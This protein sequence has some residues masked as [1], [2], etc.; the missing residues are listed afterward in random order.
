LSSAQLWVR[1]FEQV[2]CYA[3][4]CNCF[5]GHYCVACAQYCILRLL[6]GPHAQIWG[7]RAT[8]DA[9]L[10]T[11]YRAWRAHSAAMAPAS[12]KHARGCRFYGHACVLV[13]MACGCCLTMQAGR[14]KDGQYFIQYCDCG[15]QTSVAAVWWH[16]HICVQQVWFLSMSTGFVGHHITVITCTVRNLCKL[17][18]DHCPGHTKP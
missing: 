15:T 4:V 17:T 5:V 13:V 8:P 11:S 12:L 6:H 7:G 9:A 2:A 14:P 16:L 18:A 1:V 3:C 10:P